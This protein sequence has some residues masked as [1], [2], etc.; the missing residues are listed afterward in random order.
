MDSLGAASADRA[1]EHGHRIVWVAPLLESD[2]VGLGLTDTQQL[3]RAPARIK[4][5]AADDDQE[6]NGEPHDG[7]SKHILNRF[8]VPTET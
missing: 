8:R 5:S 7:R 3:D 6:L 1:S 2:Q 4:F